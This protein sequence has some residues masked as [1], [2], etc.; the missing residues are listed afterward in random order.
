MTDTIISSQFISGIKLAKD[1]LALLKQQ[2]NL[3]DVRKYDQIALSIF[4][5]VV[6]GSVRYCCWAGGKLAMPPADL[7]ESNPPLPALS[8]AGQ[9][10]VQAMMKLPF[11]QGKLAFIEL[12]VGATPLQEKVVRAFQNTPSD[13]MLCFFGDLAGALDGKMA[14]CFNVHGLIDVRDCVG[15]VPPAPILQ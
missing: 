14:P 11:F 13:M 8:P 6:D 4:E 9:A 1:E 12:L 3:K 15:I 5:V 10:T 7:A 2:F